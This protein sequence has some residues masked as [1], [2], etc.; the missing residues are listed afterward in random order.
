M[1]KKTLLA[2]TNVANEC[3][4]LCLFVSPSKHT[5]GY[6]SVASFIDFAAT[7]K[8]IIQV[9][10]RRPVGQCRNNIFVVKRGNGAS[11]DVLS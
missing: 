3:L 7:Q 11:T 1:K 6:M 8:L 4:L 10:L 2:A 9:G 5:V